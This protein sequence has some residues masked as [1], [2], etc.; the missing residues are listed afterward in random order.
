MNFIDKA[1]EEKLTGDDFLQA[2]SNYLDEPEIE[3]LLEQ[4]P[5]FVKDVITIIDY[6]YTKQ[7]ESMDEVINGSL[8]DKF[9]D[10]IGALERCGLN[11]E[12]DVLKHAKEL[13]DI[14]PD[15]YEE[16]WDLIEKQL[17]YYNDYEGFWEAVRTYINN[18]LS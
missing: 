13:N 6:D 3:S 16:Q 5:L 18:N 12:V 1:F 11:S 7:M 15:D 9:P 4:Y 10:I 14:S 2:M 8:A 17:A